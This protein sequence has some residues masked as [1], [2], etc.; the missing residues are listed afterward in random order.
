MSGIAGTQEA[1]RKYCQRKKPL[2]ICALVLQNTTTSGILDSISSLLHTY[3]GFHTLL[4]AGNLNRSW[5]K[6]SKYID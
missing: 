3:F 2:S 1:T 6:L 4:V 5:K